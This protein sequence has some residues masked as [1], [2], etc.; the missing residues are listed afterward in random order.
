MLSPLGRQ[1]HRAAQARGIGAHRHTGSSALGPGLGP[2]GLGAQEVD[3]LEASPHGIAV[4]L[5]GYWHLN[6]RWQT[7]LFYD[8][9]RA[10]ELGT[11]DVTLQ[12]AGAGVN[13]IWSKRFS[14]NL[15]VASTMEDVVPGQDGSQVLLQLQAR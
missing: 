13:F 15:L 3:A 1:Q 10:T 11:R 6:E 4:N 14:V 12:S 5:E 8:Y 7:F 2:R 9:G